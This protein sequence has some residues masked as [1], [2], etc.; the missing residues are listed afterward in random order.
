MA[1]VSLEEVQLAPA[2]VADAERLTRFMLD[3]R[4]F[5]APYDPPRG[6][7]FFTV[8]GQRRELESVVAAA[9][10][11]TR[12]RF[13]IVAGEELLGW[14]TV[15]NIVRGPFQSANLGYS[16]GE[17]YNGQGIGT[18]AVELARDWA[19]GEAGLH[20]LEAGTL[21]H[22]RASQRVLEKN[23]FERIGTARRYLFIAGEWSD[24]VLFQRLA[25]D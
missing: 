8:E 7:E 22:N 14:L 21:V 15:S 18:R 3:Q 6:D 12:Q 1:V 11:G 2:R 4:A 25:D 5:L 24:H 20:R 19:F 17:Q 9:S 13:L 16:V 10:V 23:G